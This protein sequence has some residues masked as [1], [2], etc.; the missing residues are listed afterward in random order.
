MEPTEYV[1]KIN[2]FISPDD[3]FALGLIRISIMF[4]NFMMDGRAGEGGFKPPFP[5]KA[6]AVHRVGE[7]GCI[8][9]SS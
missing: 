1:V 5:K 8:Y 3:F 4:Y 9:C 2:S 7:I 6:G